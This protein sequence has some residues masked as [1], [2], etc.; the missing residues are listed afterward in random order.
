V[1]A[2]FIYPTGAPEA[3]DLAQKILLE[4]AASVPDTVT[5]STLAIIRDNTG[6]LDNKLMF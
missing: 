5:A 3:L 1:G 6:E 2:T 4:C